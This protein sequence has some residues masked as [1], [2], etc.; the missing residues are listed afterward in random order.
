MD[1]RPA[2]RVRRSGGPDS[3]DEPG[4]HRA[5]AAGRPASG[6]GSAES[7]FIAVLSHELRNPLAVIRAALYVL[8]HGVSNGEGAVNARVV[9]D[10]QVGTWFGWSMISST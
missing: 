2:V 10:R 7:E 6:G 4:H 3:G 8:E 5:A 1:G 9:I